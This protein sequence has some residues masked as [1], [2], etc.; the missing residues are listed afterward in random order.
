MDRCSYATVTSRGVDSPSCSSSCGLFLDKRLPLDQL[1]RRIQG[2]NALVISNKVLA[3][4]V[5]V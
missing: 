5:I 2:R 3:P 4:D 1:G